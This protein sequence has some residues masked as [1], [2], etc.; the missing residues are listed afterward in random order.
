MSMKYYVVQFGCLLIFLLML[1][2]LSLAPVRGSKR[3]VSTQ[4]TALNGNRNSA[5]P[6]STLREAIYTRKVDKED[7]IA[8]VEQLDM[9]NG[10]K[11]IPKQRVSGKWELVFSSLIGSGYFPVKETCDFYG[12]SLI[13]SWGPIPLGG[14]EGSSRIASEKPLIVEF[15]NEAYV[16]GPLRIRVP[17]K[18]RSYRF[19]YTDNEFAVAISSSGGS[20]LLRKEM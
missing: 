13:S 11:K 4:C 14:F 8:A 5:D 18:P 2:G 17:P 16:L 3:R 15:E 10:K 9:K 12:F 7:V 19:L 6:I 1:P 20:T